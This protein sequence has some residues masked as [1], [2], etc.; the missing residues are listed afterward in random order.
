MNKTHIAIL[1]GGLSGLYAAFLLEKKGIN[2]Y[3]LLEARETFGGRIKSASI[4]AHSSPEAE[5]E[6]NISDRFDLG[7]TWFWPDIQSELDR[8]VQDLGIE[9]FEQFEDG[10]IVLERSP[11]ESPTRMA[12]YISSPASIRL[13]GG[14]GSLIQALRN[15]LNPDRLMTRQLVNRLEINNQVVD[16]VSTDAFGQV[17][18]RCAE[19]VLLAIPP[20]LIENNIEFV[21]ALPNTLSQQWRGTATWMSS[22][23]KYI[24]TYETPFW[25]ESGLSGGARSAFG[26]LGEIHDASVPGGSAALFG[27]FRIPS[28][29]RKN[30]TEDELRTHCRAQ[31]VRL[32]GPQ[33]AKPIMDII[34]DWAIDPFTATH[35]DLNDIGFHGQVPDT[36]PSV[37]PWRD[38]ITGIAS[39]WSPHFPGYVAGAIEAARLGVQASF[40]QFSQLSSVN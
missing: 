6:N 29:I 22:H 25:R 12:G 8:L 19:H 16:I 15:K 3:V 9:C 17:T 33:A 27:F 28:H 32:F 1:G 18:S 20:R 10:D 26:I 40:D 21:P 35:A 24:A 7:P 14:M 30:I 39:E 31:L 11:N 36:S 37:E 13:H 38:R 23:A 4:C 34:K 5:S 2:D